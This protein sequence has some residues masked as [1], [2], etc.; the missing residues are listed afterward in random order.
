MIRHIKILIVLSLVF[1]SLLYAQTQN[2]TENGSYNEENAPYILIY[3]DTFFL[4]MKMIKT[5]YFYN[6]TDT[7]ENVEIKDS[8]KGNAFYNFNAAFKVGGMIDKYEIMDHAQLMFEISKGTYYSF[9]L[10]FGIEYYYTNNLSIECA[11]G[12]YS[13][14]VVSNFDIYLP[15]VNDKDIKT[16]HE[17]DLNLLDCGLA[18]LGKYALTNNFQLIGGVRFGL[19]LN[20]N[21]DHHVTILS[22][23]AIYSD[24]SKEREFQN[25]KIR[26]T[27]GHFATIF[28]ASYKMSLKDN[29]YN[30]IFSLSYENGFNMLEMSSKLQFYSFN[31]GVTLAY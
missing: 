1:S 22:N 3:E 27:G 9:S 13:S 21:Y 5:N 10:S 2:E 11:L 18:F 28:G 6:K 14:K 7:V 17:I 8:L 24:G 4:P 15:I 12:I 25:Q 31:L 19:N 16:A 20:A 29:N 26:G 30:L 23:G